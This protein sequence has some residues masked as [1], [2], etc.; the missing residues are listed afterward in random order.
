M[1]VL[2]PRPAPPDVN[3]ETDN[4]REN[5]SYGLQCKWLV[6]FWSGGNT[7]VAADKHVDWDRQGKV[8]ISDDIL[9]VGSFKLNNNYN[10]LLLKSTEE[11]AERIEIE[12]DWS[13]L[14]MMSMEEW[15]CFRQ[16]RQMLLRARQTTSRTSSRPDKFEV[17]AENWKYFFVPTSEYNHYQLFS[18]RWLPEKSSLVQSRYIYDVESPFR[19]NNIT[20]G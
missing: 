4:E 3:I 5:S 18:L 1:I 2:T 20:F 19:R 6:M 7:H 8:E 9:T 10:S 16:K 12:K 13:S 11:D 17:R 14:L 15:Y